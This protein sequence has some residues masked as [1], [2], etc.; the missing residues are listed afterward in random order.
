MNFH[1]LVITL[2]RIEDGENVV[3]GD[4]EHTVCKEGKTPTDTQHAT[5]SQ[6][7]PN[8]MA[9]CG[10]LSV[11]LETKKPDHHDDEGG[12]GEDED[13]R[14]VAYVDDVVHVNVRYPAPWKITIC[15]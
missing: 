11:S 1:F 14:I 6:D 12:E 15:Q 10:D 8:T 13:Q 7:D 9:I 4:L 5:Q 2:E 3:G